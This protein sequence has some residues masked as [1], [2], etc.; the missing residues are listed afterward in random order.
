MSS[1][2][3][4]LDEVSLHIDTTALDP[5]A[6]ARPELVMGILVALVGLTIAIAGAKGSH[7]A[8]SIFTPLAAAVAW[9]LAH[10]HLN[11]FAWLGFASP[12][13]DLLSRSSVEFTARAFALMVGASAQVFIVIMLWAVGGERQRWGAAALVALSISLC[14]GGVI[15]F[16]GRSA[17]RDFHHAVKSASPFP[18]VIVPEEPP[19]A[20]VGL[21]KKVKPYVESAGA[22]SGWLFVSRVT[23]DA[24]SA[25]AWDVEE[26]T[27]SPAAPGLNTISFHRERGPL[28]LDFTYPITGV[29]DE[30]PTWLPLA[31]GNRWEF[32]ATAPLGLDRTRAKYAKKNVALP[33]PT[34]SLEVMSAFERDGFR[35]YLVQVVRG[36]ESTT[37]ELMR[38]NGSL[39]NFGGIVELAGQ[40]NCRV[41][42]LWAKSQCTCDDTHVQYCLEIEQDGFG[43]FL[44]LALAVVSVGITEMTGAMNGVG[45]AHERRGLLATRWVVDGVEH[46]L[47]AP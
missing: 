38:Q 41:P 16:A 12:C 8:W 13:V 15:A 43:L 14:T 33:P 36:A 39:L 28:S 21:Q 9:V 27:L 18:N 6:N 44:R 17:L 34:V 19:R 4:V 42:F 22:R 11:G 35:G 45:E 7:K 30:G 37:V 23:F 3:E 32:I 46:R 10:L 5:T 31:Q 40:H 26:L 25:K 47:N 20:H 1:C 2:T 29:A 24:A